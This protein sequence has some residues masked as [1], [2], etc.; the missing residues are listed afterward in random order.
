MA[1]ANARGIVATMIYLQVLQHGPKH[2]ASQ[3]KREAV[4]GYLLAAEVV[5]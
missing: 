1:R 3:F 2:A 5:D 4:G